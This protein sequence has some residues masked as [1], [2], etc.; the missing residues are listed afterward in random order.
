MKLGL[1][2]TA[3]SGLLAAGGFYMSEATEGTDVVKTVAAS[4]E[5][6]YAGFKR[7]LGAR[8]LGEDSGDGSYTVDSETDGGSGQG[9]PIN[10]EVKSQP[11]ESIDYTLTKNDV[12]IHIVVRFEPL[13]GGRATKV[14]AD[15][16]FPP[17]PAR[18]EESKGAGTGFVGFLFEQGFSLMVDDVAAAVE[19]GDFSMFEAV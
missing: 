12:A 9:A 16:D 6:T 5:D 15:V 2:V 8:L 13:D 17:S 1:I 11:Y 4:P 10:L 14:L 3:F 19:S 7:A 18:P